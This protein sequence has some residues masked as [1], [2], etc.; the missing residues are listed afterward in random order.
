MDPQVDKP[1]DIVEQ[2]REMRKV[3]KTMHADFN[4]EVANG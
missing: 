4:R 1:R 3:Y 2:A